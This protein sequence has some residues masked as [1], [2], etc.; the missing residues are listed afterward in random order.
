MGRRT[1]AASLIK[2]D[3]TIVFGVIE[4]ARTRITS[5][6]WPTMDEQH[7]NALCVARFVD[8]ER[9]GAG[10]AQLV[11]SIG[12]DFWKE[13]LHAMTLSLEW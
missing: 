7:R 4:A 10:H 12:F 1:A 6:P 5:A 8:V 11:T 9:M 13:D 3:N 2:C